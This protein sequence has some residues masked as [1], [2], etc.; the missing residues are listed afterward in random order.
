MMTF[1]CVVM[2]D[3]SYGRLKFG[4]RCPATEITRDAIGRLGRDEPHVR[5]V[6]RLT[7]RLGIQQNHS[8]AASRRPAASSKAQASM[9][10]KA[11]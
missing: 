2:N 5:R 10:T 6:D 8:C 3:R 9:P 1:C 11:W 4:K 7:D